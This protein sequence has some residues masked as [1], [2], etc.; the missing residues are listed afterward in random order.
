MAV[1]NH[2]ERNSMRRQ[3]SIACR[4]NGTDDW[5]LGARPGLEEG[6]SFEE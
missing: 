2:T 3:N 6:E 4:Q 5:P 1:S